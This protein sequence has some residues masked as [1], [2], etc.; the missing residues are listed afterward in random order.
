MLY[1]AFDGSYG[2]SEGMAIVDNDTF[3]DHFYNY[4]DECSDW[5]R[6]SFAKWYESNIHDFTQAKNLEWAC[7]VCEEWLE[8][9]R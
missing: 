1:V 9:E 2:D 3:D 7:S 8:S 4:L 6:P 5:L